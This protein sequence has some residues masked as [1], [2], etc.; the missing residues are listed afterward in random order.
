M[1]PNQVAP[2]PAE[3]YVA[4]TAK[5]SICKRVV[6][7]VK[8][9]SKTIQSAVS[10]TVAVAP[11]LISLFAAREMA[12]VDGML[13]NPKLSAV[14]WLRE[15]MPRVYTYDMNHLLP[16]VGDIT[17]NAIGLS[18]GELVEVDRN[19]Y[20]MLA[21]TVDAGG[22]KAAPE[23]LRQLGSQAFKDPGTPF[24]AYVY[25][26]DDKQKQS[27]EVMDLWNG[28][29]RPTTNPY[30]D[31]DPRS[32]VWST[33][34]SRVKAGD[35]PVFVDLDGDP[36]TYTPTEYLARETVASL[37][38]RGDHAGS[39]YS[40]TG[41]YYAW[42]T[43]RL[44]TNYQVLDPWMTGQ[45]PGLHK[46]VGQVKSELT[47]AWLGGKG[48]GPF[49]PAN[50]VDKA[51]G[52]MKKIAGGPQTGLADAAISLDRDILT[53]VQT[54]WVKLMRESGPGR[55][56]ELLQPLAKAWIDLA[57]SDDPQ[58]S[59]PGA[60]QLKALEGEPPAVVSRPYDRAMGVGE[61]IDHTLDGLGINERKQLMSNVRD[62]LRAHLPQLQAREQ[63]LRTQL[64][65]SYPGI[66]VKAAVEGKADPA[67]LKPLQ[68]Q[69]NGSP[70]KLQ[71]QAARYWDLMDWAVNANTRYGD[72][73]LSLKGDSPEFSR[74][75]LAVSEF[76]NQSQK[77]Q[78]ISALG[79]GPSR[80]QPL[81]L[82]QSEKEPT[83]IS[84]VF[85][86]GGGKGFAYIECIKQ[87]MDSLNASSANLA[88]D[89]FVGT[90][91]GA[92]TAGL[93]AGGYDQ[94]ELSDVMG[95][96]DFKKFDADAVWLEGGVDPKVRGIDRTGMFSTQK[97]Y[98]TLYDLL[99]KKLGIEGRPIL[100]RDLPYKFTACSTVLDTNL[101]ADDPL[102]KL[103]GTDGR[104]KMSSDDTPNFDVVGAICGSAAVPGFF[105]SPQM[106]VLREDKRYHIQFC[107]GGTVE[108]M[109]MTEADPSQAMV[110]L[111]AHFEAIDPKTGQNVGLSTLNFDSGNLDVINQHN[112]ELYQS[113]APQLGKFLND[114]RPERAVLAL[115]LSTVGNL[116]LPIVQGPTRAATEVLSARAAVDGLPQMDT[117]AGRKVTDMTAHSPVLS[118]RLAGAAF[119]L[120]MQAPGSGTPMDWHINGKNSYA[121]PSHEAA[122]VLTALTSAGA[123]A[124]S[125]A[126]RPYEK[127]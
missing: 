18:P 91:A 110:M 127:V 53:G 21:P 10:S 75:P 100:F 55:R 54:H 25:L 70:S 48:V 65:S 89:Q 72:I 28:P 121:P 119:D 106:E 78:H 109:P 14:E 29:N 50:R 8:S 3:S 111:P 63:E 62:Q 33:L 122:G 35:Y 5:I 103:I 94:N 69:V 37:W 87:L 20:Q 79:D 83:K 11:T 76:F 17:Q 22:K 26:G 105:N 4:T 90:S 31:K 71:S 42:L 101:P 102:R 99:S 77:A 124:F 51:F 59:P 43:Q 67:S 123:A 44:D 68:N 84:M 85:E 96:L 113:F 57:L 16:K 114:V 32:V 125:A 107:D 98:T 81:G 88:V 1:P 19:L 108:N 64:G 126:H 40:Q 82:G 23:F 6:N 120:F 115:K 13:G 27:K 56:E 47:P 9:I 34:D 41:A 74:D 97:M 46:Q 58:V 39:A 66:D 95:K 93:L 80:V 15:R 60:P 45:N 112:K 2:A 117:A 12:R 73:D 118:R 86:G 116:P 61:V 104:I 30:S 92:I 7:E 24:A 49:P 52:T 38:Q 36:T